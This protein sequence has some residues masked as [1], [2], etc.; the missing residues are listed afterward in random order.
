M[1]EYNEITEKKYIVYEG[2]PFEVLSSHVFRKQQRKPVNAVK[3]R[4]VITGSIKEVSFHVSE[5]V[6]EA[7]IESR[8]IKYLYKNKEQYWFCEATDPSKRF[9][10]KEQILGIG[11][12]FLKANS[13][14]TASVF[15]EQIIGIRMP[16]KAE[17]KVTEA[18]PAVRGD[19]V[20]GG[21]KLVTLETGATVLVPMFV[22]QGDVIRVNTENGE[23]TDRL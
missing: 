7:D 22:E 17:L 2:A 16:I 1:L 6:E 3:M 12:R 14:V 23:Y 8:E 5:K 4:N 9:E 15:E 11:I 20:K 10:L 19:T 18:N 21:N 13:V